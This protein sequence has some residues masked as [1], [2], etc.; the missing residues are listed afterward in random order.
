MSG[1]SG[2]DACQREQGEKWENRE[3]VHGDDPTMGKGIGNIYAR[4]GQGQANDL[5]KGG[6]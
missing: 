1:S 2:G 3:K 4:F 5:S 6:W